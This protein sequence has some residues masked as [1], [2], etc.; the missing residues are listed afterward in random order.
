M[1]TT[2][3][4]PAK[5]INAGT[6]PATVLATTAP[7]GDNDNS[8][9]TTAFV[10][11]TLSDTFSTYYGTIYNKSTFTSG[12]LSSDFVNN[13]STNIISSNKIQFSGGNNGYTQSLGLTQKR[14]TERWIVSGIFQVPSVVNSTSYGFGIGF[15]S[16]T[17]LNPSNVIAK[18]NTITGS[19]TIDMYMG[20]NSNVGTSSP[21]TFS[22]NDLIRLS[23]ERDG[24]IFIARAVNITTGG[25]E[26]NLF[27]RAT[28]NGILMP[29]SGRPS[30][31]SFGGTFNVSSFKYELREPKNSQLVLIGDSKM[32]GYY[33]SRFDNRLGTLLQKRILSTTI[34]SGSSETTLEV[35]DRIQEIVDIAPKQVILGIG[36]NDVRTSVSSAVYLARYDAI[37][38]ALVSAGTEVIH[39]MPMYEPIINQTPL[40]NHI[41]ST[42]PGKYID[43]SE[44]QTNYTNYLYSDL[45]HP[46]DKGNL[47]LEKLIL[48]SGLI[49]QLKPSHKVP[50]NIV[51][52]G[53]LTDDY[54]IQTAPDIKF[55]FSTYA[56]IANTIESTDL[57]GTTP[58]RFDLRG[59][60][61]NFSSGTAAPFLTLD[62]V[63]VFNF[64]QDGDHTIGNSSNS[65]VL[66]INTT[67]LGSGE[68][69]SSPWIYGTGG[70]T[71]LP[72]LNTGNKAIIGYSGATLGWTSAVEITNTSSAF[73]N[74]LLM[75]SGGSTGIGV[76]A[77]TARLHLP[78]GTATAGTAQLKLENS[79][80]L[81][82]P[83]DGA[84]EKTASHIYATIG[85]TRYQLDQ[86][87]FFFGPMFGGV[88]TSLD[89]LVPIAL[90][91]NQT[92]TTYTLQD[93]DNA[94]VVTL[95]NA[96][97]ITL[98]VPAGL[99]AGFNCSIV[100][101]GAGQVTIASSGTTIHN[102]QSFTKTAGQYSAITILQYSTN[103]F[104]TQGDMI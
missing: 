47:Y 66:H 15:R 21:L 90:Y 30:I 97:A 65:K 43:T 8:I 18:F 31:F 92:G 89:P 63:G 39:M 55:K 29:N 25:T 103:N 37:V 53:I 22:A 93:S 19:G 61:Y 88:G 2:K 104:L 91:N 24:E 84:I 101:L 56:S 16:V 3:I 46:N 7:L 100:Q 70:L 38:A 17:V 87:D 12:D 74:L 34:S 72:G 11:T 68:A 50:D 78:A 35:L 1:A 67:L 77:P 80:L 57:L 98:T 44:L 6:L 49:K 10:N 13:G 79:T 71:L 69:P 20:A 81:T 27:F 51:G 54:S 102:R 36:S 32:Q 14:N 95:T 94:K 75:K 62:S 9:A 64:A 76:N 85:S 52:T 59:S 41:I 82:T 33:V 60:S 23:L 26:V 99:R 96:S 45:I 48:E 58:K 40:A 4:N 73:G 5:D 83:E 86:E 28:A 42:Y